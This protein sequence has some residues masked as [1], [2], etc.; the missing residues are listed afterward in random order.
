MSGLAFGAI[1]AFVDT[2]VAYG[3][4]GASLG[5][6]Q[7]IV[8]RTYVRRPVV[9]LI[10]TFVGVLVAWV[11]GALGAAVLFYPLLT[12][13]RLIWLVP[14]LPP[15]PDWLQALLLAVSGACIGGAVVGMLQSARSVGTRHQAVLWMFASAIGALGFWIAVMGVEIPTDSIL[16]PNQVARLT[17]GTLGGLAYALIT[18]PA[19]PQ[20]I[21]QPHER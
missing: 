18:A 19:L 17:A 5:V 20:L 16:S 4:L 11:V 3:T 9:W 15:A 13:A 2:L 12:A 14:G 6:V 7:A 1:N 8:L 21:A 10:R